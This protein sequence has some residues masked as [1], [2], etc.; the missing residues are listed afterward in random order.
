[1]EEVGD[2]SLHLCKRCGVVHLLHE[3][4]QVADGVFIRTVRTLTPRQIAILRAVAA[5]EGLSQ[6][7]VMVATGI[8]RSTVSSM[9]R[10]LV[11]RGYLA[12]KRIKDD[13]RTYAVRPTDAGR[14]VLDGA[15]P[16]A[17]KVEI[18][19]LKRFT[20]AERDRFLKLLAIF[21]KDRTA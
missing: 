5:F 20:T 10:S 1:V 6:T 4:T 16:M 17:E 21:A 7:D 14:R 18:G 15:K 11:K 3:A 12:R 8:D 19:L 9:T 2:L 13:A